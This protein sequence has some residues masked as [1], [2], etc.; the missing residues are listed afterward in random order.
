VTP[1]LVPA[2]EVLRDPRAARRWKNGASLAAASRRGSG[3][4][5]RLLVTATRACYSRD[6]IDAWFRA[7]EARRAERLEILRARAAKMRAA[8]AEKRAAAR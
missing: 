6:T 4:T 8:L 7:E 2:E 3:P 5:P 1:D